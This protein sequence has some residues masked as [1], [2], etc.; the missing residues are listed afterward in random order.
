V[1]ANGSLSSRQSGEGDIRK[2]LVEAD[3]VECVVALPTQLFYTT[4]IPVCLW[5][6]TKDKSD[7][8]V[9][10][11]LSQRSRPGEVLFIDARAMGHMAGRTIRELSDADIAQIARAFNAWRGETPDQHYD[12]V[13]GFCASVTLDEIRAH[14]HLLTPGRYV[15][16]KEGDGD[17]EPIQDKIDRLTQ[18]VKDGFES[19]VELQAGVLQDLARLTVTSD[20]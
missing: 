16:S 13:P 14:D 6:L 1:L 7:R 10:S 19:R 11:E 2:N 5:F 15:G 17:D 18:V 8:K 9:Q 4:G 12:D 20:D 3:L